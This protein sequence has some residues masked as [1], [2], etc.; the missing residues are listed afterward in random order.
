MA[1]SGFPDFIYIIV[2]PRL[3]NAVPFHPFGG[4]NEDDVVILEKYLENTAVYY[5]DIETKTVGLQT[6]RMHLRFE[7]KTNYWLGG[8]LKNFCYIT[9]TAYWT[10][11]GTTVNWSIFGN[12][13]TNAGSPS[14]TSASDGTYTFRELFLNNPTPN[15]VS[16][17][18]VTGFRVQGGTGYPNAY[19]I[20][21]DCFKALDEYVEPPDAEF[22][23]TP[24]SGAAT[25]SVDFTDESVG[26]PTSWFWD[27]GDGFYSLEQNPT[28]DY[29]R[30]G[31]YTVSLT[32]WG[33]FGSLSET[34]VAYITVTE[35]P[36]VTENPV[37]IRFATEPTE[38]EGWSEYSGDN[39]VKPYQYWAAWRISDQNEVPRNLFFD[40]DLLWLELMTY[41]RV[42]SFKPYPLDFYF[43]IEWEKWG[44]EE[45][46]S[47]M[48][49]HDKLEHDV[50]HV[51]LRPEDPAN[52][53]ETGYD[54]SGFRTNLEISLED[55]VDGEKIT[56]RAVTDDIPENGD[57]VFI[58]NKV[59][60]RRHQLVVKG[61]A[62]EVQG[63][64]ISHEFIAKQKPGNRTERRMGERD[65]QITLLN[66]I[67]CHV[68]RGNYS[69]NRATKGN[70]GNTYGAVTGP[71][72]IAM[73]AAQLTSALVLD[74]ASPTGYTIIMWSQTGAPG[75]IVGIN[76]VEYA[77][78]G[79][80]YLLYG[81][82]A[83]VLPADVTVLNGSL[84]YDLRIFSTS[85][86]DMATVV[87][88]Y[89]Y[90][91]VTR[92]SGKAIV[93]YG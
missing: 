87:L 27:F 41:D 56:P 78:S 42:T 75:P 88:P 92:N 13:M 45:V 2:G 19:T 30:S 63:V 68:T 7:N 14:A 93:P 89:V 1:V 53:G 28:H 71:D 20:D 50:T 23:G 35:D 44:R 64:G 12:D 55:Y 46:V 90:N 34:K 26:D 21:S 4:Y 76:L 24:T 39:W 10:F 58:G 9:G 32:I 52:R 36:N 15:I 38:G 86:A 73:T 57:A 43:E 69:Y 40:E 72:G 3:E 62:S 6:S 77:A 74:N 17:A 16:F 59:E 25:L 48:D 81:G 11:F 54:A 8:L 47:P 51:Y 5:R 67:I 61:E 66:G 84:I 31:V 22:S 18:S 82:G 37:C 70:L 29:T 83:G 33:D 60:Y 79:S 85:I 91:D 65:I 80:W 49:E